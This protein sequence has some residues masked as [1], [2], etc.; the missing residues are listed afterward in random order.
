MLRNF[1]VIC[2]L[3]IHF[4]GFAQQDNEI[5][6]SKKTPLSIYTAG[7]PKIIYDFSGDL[8]SHYLSLTEFKFRIVNQENIER[9]LFT[10][11]FRN[12]DRSGSV[13]DYETYRK[14]DLNKCFIVV[15]DL[16]TINRFNDNL[17]SGSH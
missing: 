14:A 5:A 9:N 11:D 8:P 15:P 17:V 1:I 4:T 10:I 7:T 13:Y 12:I 3:V 16:F 2:F 6:E